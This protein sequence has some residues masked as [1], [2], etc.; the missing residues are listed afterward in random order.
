LKIGSAIQEGCMGRTIAAVAGGVALGIAVAF[1]NAGAF[2]FPWG[3]G[4]EPAKPQSAA[5]PP[6]TMT[7]QTHL[8]APANAPEPTEKG[9]ALP[10]WAPLVKHVMPTVVNVAVTQEVKSSDPSMGGPEEGPGG[11][12]GEGGGGG[13][14]GGGEANPFGGQG[15]P[16][17]FGGGQDPFEQFRHFFGQMP[18]QYKEHGLGSGVI[19]T[20]DG[21]ILTN[22]H[23]V[24]SADEIHVTLMDKREFTAKVVGKDPKTDLALIKIDTNETLPYASLGN[25]N[26]AEVGDWVLAIGSPF[27]FNLTVT[28][29]IISAKGRALGGNYDNFIQ[30]DASINPGNSGGPLFDTQGQ[31]IGINTAIYS[32]TGSNAGI[33]FAIP[34]DL[35][36]NV[37]D[38]LRTHG[39]VVRGWLGV[40]IQE[41]TPALAQSFGLPQPVGALVAGVDK[42]G[43]AFKAGIER[44]DII[45]KFAGDV[46]HDEH[47]LPELVAQTAIGKKVPVEVIRGGKHT[48]IEVTVAE[49]KEQ[50]LA[51]AEEAG[52]AGSNW[53]LTVQDLTPD[54][55][56]QIG[57]PN[58]GKGVVIR[59]IKPDSPAAD[60]GLQ[61][62]DL[63]LE[64]DHQKVGTADDFATLAKGAQKNK[65]SA[66]LL[67]QRGDST[68]YT[69]INPES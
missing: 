57:I 34:I 27:G 20:P 44:G 17:P 64:V 15:G 62:G 25:S 31:V 53:G 60:A 13:G 7:A 1:A 37:M 5:P 35:A 6:H 12:E 54:I 66:L 3:S 14:G 33:G 18:R 10:T 38:Q 52:A 51:S 2:Q 59:S 21:Y 40:E 26:K 48:T 30:T 42:T 19:V 28:S 65:K 43:P 4:D 67:V 68:L 56:H 49:L 22:N 8:P 47:E 61:P 32:S 46:V 55:A 50:Q 41:V 11:G 63:I 39:R 23:V 36:K 69:V 45:V 16:S 29:G 24:G 9:I 58:A